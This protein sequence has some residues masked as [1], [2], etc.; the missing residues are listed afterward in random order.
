MA[1]KK[2]YPLYDGSIGAGTHDINHKEGARFVE[3]EV[4]LVSPEHDGLIYSGRSVAL[5]GDGYVDLS[6][7]GRYIVYY[8]FAQKRHVQ[9]DTTTGLEA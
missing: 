9:I 4:K 8:D 6:D 2:L 1:K 7:V 5:S 3:N